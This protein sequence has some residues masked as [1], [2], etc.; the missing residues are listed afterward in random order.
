MT[1]ASA[2]LGREVMRAAGDPVADFS[3]KDVV[4]PTLVGST[5]LL[6]GLGFLFG[7]LTG[8]QVKVAW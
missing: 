4:L 1:S 2:L 8:K 6:G 7:A 3:F 5:I